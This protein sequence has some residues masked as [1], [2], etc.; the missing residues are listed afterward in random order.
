LQP[1][2][3]EVAEKIGDEQRLLLKA[4][5]YWSEPL[6][7]EL[8]QAAPAR[9]VGGN[10]LF[11]SGGYETQS[12]KW[13]DVSPNE[14]YLM[15]WSDTDFIVRTLAAW[16]KVHGIDWAIYSA[17][18]HVSDVVRGNPCEKLGEFLE[19][20]PEMS[21][22]AP[23]MVPEIDQKFKNRCEP[24]QL[25]VPAT[26]SAGVLTEGAPTKKPWWRLW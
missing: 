10:S 25:V 3:T 19:G 22:L 21:G 2:S 23:D 20:L 8:E 26:P 18:D 4:R 6:H 11:S 17:G 24:P 9:L 12:G 14:D 7:V 16:S 5:C 15:A 13:V 1:V